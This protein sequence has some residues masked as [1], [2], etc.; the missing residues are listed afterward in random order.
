MAL[1][2]MLCCCSGFF[3]L[4]V[5]K[6]EDTD[7]F[8]DGHP[9]KRNYGNVVLANFEIYNRNFDPKNIPSNY[10]LPDE[11]FRVLNTDMKERTS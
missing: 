4:C 9:E 2:K 10:I 8:I 3:N 1:K 5:D 6:T 11:L 7:I